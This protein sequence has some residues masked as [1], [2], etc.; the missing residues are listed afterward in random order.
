MKKQNKIR[1]KIF[2][3]YIIEQLFI[4]HKYLPSGLSI[5]TDMNNVIF[6]NFLKIEGA[7]KFYIFTFSCIV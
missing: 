3:H 4:T 6:G 7:N 2:I 1:R 5:I